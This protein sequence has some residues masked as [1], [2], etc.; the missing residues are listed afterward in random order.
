M[1]TLLAFIVAIAVLVVFH[2]LGHY[3]VARRCGVKVLRFSVGFGR[4]LYS[5][6][7]GNGET[8]WALS[9]IPLGG[10]VKMLDEREG[11]VSAT[12]LPRAFNRQP[13][14]RRMAIVVAGPVANLLLAV[15]LYWAL[16][17]YGVPG[18]K[19]VVGEIRPDTP[20]AMA[21]LREQDTILAID[22]VAVA[23]WQDARWRLLD[24]V[25]QGQ[26]AQQAQLEISSAAG[27]KALRVLHLG[28][29]TAA[30]LDGDFMA[31]LGL[32]PYQPPVYPVIGKL[33]A[34]GAGQRGGLREVI[35]SCASRVRRCRSGATGSRWCAPIRSRLCK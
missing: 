3:F 5:K 34:D 23:S 7:F 2:E 35:A 28:N 22:G 18:V 8:E 29:L 24:L 4:V 30:D 17:I 6:R 1:T 10:Y 19:P 27:G 31:K 15:L 13:V 21:Q 9:A 25:L 16:F 20:A 14:L 11:E 33:V 26:Q 12:D 32:Y